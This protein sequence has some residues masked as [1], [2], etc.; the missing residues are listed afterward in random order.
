MTS[1][2]HFLGLIAQVISL[3]GSTESK[4]GTLGGRTGMRDLLNSFKWYGKEGI[5]WLHKE[6]C[7]VF[8][9]WI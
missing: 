4:G 7:D 1:K 5:A 6:K 8:L 3:Q 9:V 2:A